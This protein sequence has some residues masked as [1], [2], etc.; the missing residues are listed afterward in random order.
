MTGS[1]IQLPRLRETTTKGAHA[2]G[3][4]LLLMVLGPR[5][6]ASVELVASLLFSTYIP[7]LVLMGMSS[8]LIGGGLGGLDAELVLMAFLAT[9]LEL[10]PE[11]CRWHPVGPPEGPEGGR[12]RPQT[13]EGWLASH[14]S[15]GC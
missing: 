7:E 15:G 1:E 13:S 3:L 6:A 2:E 9:W 12:R 14:K 4:F 11:S 10:N 8:I 5:G